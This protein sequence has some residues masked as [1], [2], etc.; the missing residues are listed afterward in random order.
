MHKAAILAQLSTNVDN[1]PRS[2]PDFNWSVRPY[3]NSHCGDT[4]WYSTNGV[5]GEHDHSV[6]GR[7]VFVSSGRARWQVRANAI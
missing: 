5:D 4:R 7:R 3:R 6:R 2:S 1:S